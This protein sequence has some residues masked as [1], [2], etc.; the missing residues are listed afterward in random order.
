MTSSGGEDVRVV[1]DEYRE[2]ADGRILRVRALVVPESEKFPE[3]V[4]YRFHYGTK[5]GET[6]LRYDNSHGVH[7]RHTRD[8]LEE[9]SF[10]GLATL[11]RRFR[12]EI[13]RELD[14]DTHD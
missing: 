2:T 6:I 14:S 13:E 9:V 11:Y 1:L 12:D 3:G 10:P 4:K 8:D 5:S 7:E